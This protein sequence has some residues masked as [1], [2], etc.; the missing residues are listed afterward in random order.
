MAENAYAGVLPVTQFGH[1]PSPAMPSSLGRECSRGVVPMGVTLAM[2]WTFVAIVVVHRLT[3][4]RFLVLSSGSVHCDDVRPWHIPSVD[5]TSC[6]VWQAVLEALR[7]PKASASGSIIKWLLT[8][9]ERRQLQKHHLPVV[10]PHLAS[11]ARYADT[12]CV[13]NAR[14][15]SVSGEV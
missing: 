7:S 14:N 10:S 3:S 15:A 5:G 4:M 1:M 13:N 6:V 12:M 8:L 9:R 11:Y 2:F